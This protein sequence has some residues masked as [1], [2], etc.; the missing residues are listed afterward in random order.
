MTIVG[1]AVDKINKKS[2]NYNKK[3]NPW[4]D[5]RYKATDWMYSLKSKELRLC[6]MFSLL[7]AVIITK[8]D[9][10]SQV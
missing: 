2:L 1:I 4:L 8:I 9:Q 10:A 5:I 6:R 3:I 7:D